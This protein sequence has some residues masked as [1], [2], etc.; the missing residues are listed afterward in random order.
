MN[1][2]AF[3]LINQ[4]VIVNKIFVSNEPIE[5]ISLSINLLFN[6]SYLIQS[7]S[8]YNEMIRQEILQSNCV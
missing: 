6:G 4:S 1:Y 8:Y 5:L 7:E 2:Y 3:Y